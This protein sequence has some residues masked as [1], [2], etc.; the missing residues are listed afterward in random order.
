MEVEIKQW[1]AKYGIAKATGRGYVDGN[2]AVEVGSMTF[3][4]AK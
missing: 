2:L 1:K 3:A 4:L